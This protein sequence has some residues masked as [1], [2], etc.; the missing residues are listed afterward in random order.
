M[1]DLIIKEAEFAQLDKMIAPIPTQYGLPLVNFFNRLVQ[2]RAQEA[3]DAEK[4]S[5]SIVKESAPAKKVST[6]VATN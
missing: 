2:L 3:Q 6:K 4:L 5:K 1:P